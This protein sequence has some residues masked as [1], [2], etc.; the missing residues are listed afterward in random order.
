MKFTFVFSMVLLF[1]ISSCSVS[2]KE[3]AYI[4]KINRL[5]QTFDSVSEKY[6]TIDTAKLNITYEVINRNLS[7][8]S[9]IDTILN[10]SVKIYT[11]LQKSFKRFIR[12]HSLIIK[13][14]DYSKNQLKALKKDIGKGKISDENMEK[15]YNVELGA[16]GSLIN[17]MGYNEQ[18]IKYQMQS[19]DVFNDHI[20]S[21][22]KRFEDK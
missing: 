11:G 9:K 15:Y 5:E 12:E 6:L 7:R 20:E 10:D 1:F 17:K 13:E 16:V 18:I 14:I 4:D 8:L 22:I 21:L 19:F 3:R 2:E